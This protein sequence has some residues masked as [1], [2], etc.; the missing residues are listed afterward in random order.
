MLSED[1][2]QKFIKEIMVN[3]KCLHIA[4]C[5]L[6]NVD[7]NLQQNLHLITMLNN[8]V[9][10]AVRSHEA[11]IRE[12]GLLC[13][14]LCCLLDRS[15]AEENITLFIHCFAKGHEALQATSLQILCDI[16]TTHPSLLTGAEEESAELPPFQRPLLKSFVRALRPASSVTVQSAAA[17]SLSK[18]LLTSRLC[19]ADSAIDDLLCALVI[20]F[21]DPRT[22]ENA[23]LRQALAYFLPVFC[24][25]RLGNCERMARVAVHV[26][27][28]VLKIADEHF[29]VEAEEDSDGDVDESATEKR[30]K[31][32]M[33]TVIGML[34]EWTDAR[35]VV[36]VDSMVI[37]ERE[38]SSADTQL[39]LTETV[40]EK[41]L[42]AGCHGQERKSLLGLLAKL[43]I[44]PPAATASPSKESELLEL[45][46]RVKELL[47][48]AISD[49]IATDAAGRNTLVKIKNAVLKIVKGTCRTDRRSTVRRGATVELGSEGELDGESDENNEAA[50]EQNVLGSDE[51][52]EAYREPE[53]EAT[54]VLEKTEIDEDENDL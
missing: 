40:L 5:M 31:A 33:G 12:R 24:H 3:L 42:S 26:V 29:T 21:F 10:P 25:S 49:G 27:H 54:Q 9:V 35:R 14:G 48:E 52:D 7:S 32:L 16:V 39:K 2:E 22:S 36:A 46:G 15:L 34:S 13:L 11:P 1:H 51:E 41:A 23:T 18:L 43:Y 53:G 38:L 30:V 37:V 19:I 45:A 8:L 47:D 17:I 44:P 20:A 4:Q 50:K 6:Q 28:E